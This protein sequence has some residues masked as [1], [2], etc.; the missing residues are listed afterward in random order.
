M[1]KVFLI[2]FIGLFLIPEATLSQQCRRNQFLIDLFGNGYVYSL[3]YERNL[4]HG[5]VFNFNIMGGVSL[6]SHFISN[7]F[8]KN[9]FESDHPLSLICC[10]GKHDNKVEIMYTSAMVFIKDHDGFE[11]DQEPYLS[12]GYRYQPCDK[13][14][15][16]RAYVSLGYKNELYSNSIVCPGVSMG[17]IF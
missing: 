1:R 3:C 6:Y 11:F 17:Y 4:L 13:R 15:C 2:L 8:G 14:I 10:I 7:R 12:L 5:S 16:L 9:E